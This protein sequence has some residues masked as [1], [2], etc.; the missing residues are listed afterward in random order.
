MIGALPGRSQGE[1][2]QA[3]HPIGPSMS[4]FDDNLAAT[5]VLWSVSP[6]AGKWGLPKTL[7]DLFEYI[8]LLFHSRCYADLGQARRKWFGLE[9][10]VHFPEAEGFYLGDWVLVMPFDNAED[11][12]GEGIEAAVSCRRR[13][14]PRIS[15]QLPPLAVDLHAFMRALRTSN[16]CLKGMQMISSLTLLNE[17]DACAVDW[18]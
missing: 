10:R 16:L 12:G 4:I 3:S 7:A 6:T 18:P 17:S 15:A 1:H 13:S 8:G 9:P 2:E 5:V 11:S 14:S